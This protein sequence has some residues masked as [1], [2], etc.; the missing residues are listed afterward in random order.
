MYG[1][2]AVI[3]PD[4]RCN[5]NCYFCWADRENI[6]NNHKNTSTTEQVIE[7]IDRARNLDVDMVVIS[8]GEPTIRKDLPEMI[9]HIERKGMVPGVASN[10]RMFSYREFTEKI[11]RKGLR[12]VHGSFYTRNPETYRKITSTDTF[13][14]NIEGM[15]NVIESEAELLINHVV[16]EENIQ[17]MSE[18][19]EFLLRKGIKDLKITMVEP[20]QDIDTPDIEEFSDKLNKNIDKFENSF[21]TLIYEGIPACLSDHPERFSEWDVTGEKYMS[22]PYERKFYPVDT[23]YRKIEKCQECK[24]DC[25]GF[26]Q[27]YIE[28]FPEKT[29]KIIRKRN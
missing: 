11:V 27:S 10:L 26:Y 6:G 16:T 3:K 1:K 29:R 18:N 21:R 8:G 12:W 20:I 4:Y 5:N 17:E 2:K 13:E 9:E 28:R 22:E 24:K 7:K 14:Q 15:E 19:I 23:K 25:K